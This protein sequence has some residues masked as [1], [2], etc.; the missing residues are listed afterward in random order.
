M[1]NKSM[2]ELIILSMN[3][4]LKDNIS[5]VHIMLETKFALW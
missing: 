5:F 1:V 2:W 4:T 3:L